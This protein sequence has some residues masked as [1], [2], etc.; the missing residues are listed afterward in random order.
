MKDLPAGWEVA[1]FEVDPDQ[2]EPCVE[3]VK[4]PP[5]AVVP[6]HALAPALSLGTRAAVIP[7]GIRSHFS[8]PQPVADR[9]Q[10]KGAMTAIGAFAPFVSSW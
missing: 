8:P 1:A 10:S 4:L 6:P 3:R 5:N 9:D 2:K 7:G